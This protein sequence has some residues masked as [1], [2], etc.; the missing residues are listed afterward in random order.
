M[1]IGWVN[2]GTFLENR[3]VLGYPQRDF[4]AEYSAKTLRDLPDVHYLESVHK[5]Q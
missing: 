2:A 4:T 3:S 5:V 1:S